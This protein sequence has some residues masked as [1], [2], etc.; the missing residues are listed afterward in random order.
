MKSRLGSKLFFLKLTGQFIIFGVLISYFAL[1]LNTMAAGRQIFEQISRAFQETHR[2]NA[3]RDRDWLYHSFIEDPSRGTLLMESLLKMIPEEE[4]DNLSFALYMKDSTGENWETASAT[5]TRRV[6]NPLED[7]HTEE[8]WTEI[9]D[10]AVE[11]GVSH[12]EAFYVGKA[13]RRL[14]LLDLTPE[15]SLRNYV[16]AIEFYQESIMQNLLKHRENL[17]FYTMAIIGLSLLLGMI[18]SQPLVRAVRSLTEGAQKV[19][20]GE[21]GVSFSNHRLDDLGILSRALDKMARDLSHRAGTMET[22]NRIDRAVL[23]SLSRGE[24]LSRVLSYIGE[25]FTGSGLAVLEREGSHFRVL[26]LTERGG[27][28]C[29]LPE[30]RMVWPFA[31][32]GANLSGIDLSS[33]E[34]F[35][36][37]FG[38]EGMGRHTAA[39]PLILDEESLGYI[40]ITRDSLDERDRASL[41]MLADQ[42]GVALKS[43]NESRSREK[44]YEGMLLALTRTVDAKSRWT[45][46]HSERVTGLALSLAERA[47]MGIELRDTIRIAGLL[48]DIGKL[49]IPESILDKPGRLSD[50]EYALVREHPRRGFEILGEIPGLE[51]VREVV[52]SHHEHWDGGGYPEGLAGKEI[53]PIARIIT[54]CD[55]YDA[56]TEERPY[57]KGF[58]PEDAR[59]FLLSG[60]GTLFDPELLD[61]FLEI[62]PSPVPGE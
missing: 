46:G 5:G 16:L 1:V 17:K 54:I 47:G 34:S 51:A 7:S 31:T 59:E 40:V 52:K 4:R 13:K 32:D 36:S 29:E 23:S 20:R 11:R 15:G 61:L 28:P 37:L 39:Y 14:F 53:P 58:P 9:L 50:G 35:R 30:E 48:H 38:E 18:F 12:R 6:V 19:S 56:V 57:R 8:T 24:L 44:L 25:Q 41:G 49:A 21:N 10:R 27:G 3:R 26:A 45:A 2:D 60:R 42:A 22:M 62:I 33:H 43:L 55:V